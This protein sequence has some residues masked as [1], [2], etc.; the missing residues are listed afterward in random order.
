MKMKFILA[1]GS[2]VWYGDA[3]LLVEGLGLFYV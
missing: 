1:S 3:E 2:V